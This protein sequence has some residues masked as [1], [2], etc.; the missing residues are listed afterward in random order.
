MRGDCRSRVC[1]LTA[2]ASGS[3]GEPC[4]WAWAGA[5]NATRPATATAPRMK[6]ARA[7]RPVMAHPPVV[8]VRRHAGAASFA[9]RSH[10]DP[11]AIGGHP[12]PGAGAVAALDHA[13][14]VDLGDDHAVTRK[15][16]FGRAHF[17]AQRQLAFADAVR[18]VFLVFLDAAR[19]FR[20]ATASAIGALVHL[21]ARAE[22]AELR[23]LRRAERACVEAVAAADAQI[24]R[25]QHD[26][27]IG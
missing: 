12:A 11:L 1:S 13:L 3:I 14:L 23:I 16:R 5:A 17:G 7:N 8:L 26:A 2:L 20:A 4:C 6:R 9:W 27:V 19:G 10:C 15:Q 18:A 21:A 24:L 25:M 22:I